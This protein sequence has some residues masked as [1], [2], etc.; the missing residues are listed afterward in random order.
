MITS[1]AHFSFTVSRIE[2]GLHFF[3]DLLGLTATPVA[4]AGD[5]FLEKIVGMSGVRL[6]ISHVHLPDG[7]DI[8]LIEYVAPKGKRVDLA[9]CNA[10]VA[11]IAF[12]VTGIHAM[13]ETMSSVGVEFVNP[14]VWAPAPGGTGKCAVCYLRGPDGI[15][16]EL[17]ERQE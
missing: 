6:R 14:P 2:E 16:I 3:C 5:G 11:H 15:T 17:L 8:E 9:T 12:N 10:G 4:E 1:T 13:Y 7:G